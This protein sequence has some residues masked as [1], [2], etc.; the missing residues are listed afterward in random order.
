MHLLLQLLGDLEEELRV[1]QR[2]AGREEAGGGRGDRSSLICPFASGRASR[3]FRR[4]FTS[5]T[6][7]D[8]DRATRHRRCFSFATSPATSPLSRVEFCHASGSR[9]VLEATCLGSAFMRLVVGGE[10]AVCVGQQSLAAPGQCHAGP[11][12][13]NARICPTS[14]SIPLRLPQPLVVAGPDSV[15]GGGDRRFPTAMDETLY[16]HAGGEEGLR[17]FTQIFYDSVLRDPLLQ[18][19]FG[20]GKAEHVAHLAAFTAESFGG[21]HTFTQRMGG[22]A[23]LIA[24]HRGL[25]ITEPQRERFVALYLAAADRAGLPDDPRFRAA[26]REHVEFGSHVAMQNSNAR[27]DAELHPLREVPQ[28]TW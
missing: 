16:A 7:L 14:R 11:A 18:P 19:L 4:R 28:W 20:A 8:F 21:P 17:R 5:R 2:Q 22:F 1:D 10:Q 15:D 24:A 9:K 27:T 13:T 26:L 25:H 3:S 12:A 6:R 23:G